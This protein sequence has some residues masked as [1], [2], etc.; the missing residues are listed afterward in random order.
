MWHP[1]FGVQ[2]RGK[3]GIM[4][5]F[6]GIGK[7]YRKVRTLASCIGEERNINV[8]ILDQWMVDRGLMG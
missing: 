8:W 6:S 4:Q 7:S 2:A 5:D 1:A 3:V